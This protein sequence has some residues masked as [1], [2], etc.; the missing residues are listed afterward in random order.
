[1]NVLI[2]G[3]WFGS[4][5]VVPEILLARLQSVPVKQ[6]DLWVMLQGVYDAQVKLG[7]K[8]RVGA[9]GA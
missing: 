9:D 3:V 4:V 5:Q 6:G 2:W 8:G 1:M 7:L